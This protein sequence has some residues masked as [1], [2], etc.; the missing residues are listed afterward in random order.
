MISID[1]ILIR[2]ASNVNLTIT[3]CYLIASQHHENKVRS[4]LQYLSYMYN[5][6]DKIEYDT[7]S[8]SDVFLLIL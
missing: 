8:F 7:D 5:I 4:V 2:A 3:N 6:S 1:S